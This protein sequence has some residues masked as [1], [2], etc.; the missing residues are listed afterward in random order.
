MYCE[1]ILLLFCVYYAKKKKK[2]VYSSPSHVDHIRQIYVTKSRA[3][4]S[5]FMCSW[6][7]LEVGWLW[8][9]CLTSLCF[10]FFFK[11][12]ITFSRLSIRLNENLYIKPLKLCL[13]RVSTLLFPGGIILSVNEVQALSL[14]KLFPMASLC[15]PLLF[16][17]CSLSHCLSPRLLFSPEL[18]TLL[19]LSSLSLL[20]LHCLVIIQ[21]SLYKAYF[22]LSSSQVKLNVATF[23]SLARHFVQ[24]SSF[25]FPSF[26]LSTKNP[27][28]AGECFSQLFSHST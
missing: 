7:H 24:V 22:L 13:Y 15:S 21:H 25:L 10:I 2:N 11:T 1:K 4:K 27:S 16:L 26:L 18:W 19:S 14:T 5:V 12:A 9:N 8:A 17:A 28:K 3:L 23:V 20:I 6:H